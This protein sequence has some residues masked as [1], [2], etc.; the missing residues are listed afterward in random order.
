VIAQTF[1]AIHTPRGRKP[2]SIREFMWRDEETRKHE[3]EQELLGWLRTMKHGKS[4]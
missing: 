3:Q 2:P 1:A 4:S